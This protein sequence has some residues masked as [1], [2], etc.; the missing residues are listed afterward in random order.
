MTLGTAQLGLKYGIA[1]KTGKPDLKSA[2]QI[3]ESAIKNGVNSFDTAPG[4]GNSEEIIGSFV[5]KLSINESFIATKIPKVQQSKDSTLQETYDNI[6]S[7]ISSSQRRLN[8]EQIPICLLHEATDMTDYDGNVTKSLLKL[9]DEGIVD[10]IGVSVYHPDEVRQFLKID[11]FDVIQI[12]INL[13]DLRLIKQGLLKDLIQRDTI[14]FARSIFLQ[15]LF[16]LENNKIPPHLHLAKKPLA[17]LN[18]L[19]QDIGKDISTIALTFVRDLA[20]ITSLVIGTETENQ[21]IE[22]IKLMDLPPLPS[23]VSDK[24]LE[25]FCE[26]PE[27]LINPSLWNKKE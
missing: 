18:K 3:L 7:V 20:G 25:I 10:K 19:S 17:D 4:Y 11:A 26:M 15:G 22:D 8:L 9:R 24:I 5:K 1:N 16:F 21:L 12:P 14:V 13:F 2:N 6:K 23:D 27:E